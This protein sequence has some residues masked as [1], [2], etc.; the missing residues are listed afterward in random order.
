MEVTHF[1][2]ETVRLQLKK[3]LLQKALRDEHEKA[4]LV[5]FREDGKDRLDEFVD[6]LMDFY[7]WDLTHQCLHVLD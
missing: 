5:A 2:K 3:V 7:S 6:F 4:S 1:Q